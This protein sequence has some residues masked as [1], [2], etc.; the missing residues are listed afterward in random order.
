ML[1]F[2]DNFSLKNLSA[3]IEGYF[4]LM[5]KCIPENY[6]NSGDLLE[7]TVKFSTIG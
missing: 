7:E 1:I 5:K 2:L 4:T 6:M 3:N